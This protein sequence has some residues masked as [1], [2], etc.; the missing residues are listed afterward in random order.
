MIRKIETTAADA[1]LGLTPA[2]LVAFLGSLPL[3][4]DVDSGIEVRVVA[5]W[6]GQIKSISGRFAAPA[7]ARA[8]Q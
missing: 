8:P 4:D 3:D 1:K 6:H 5:G 7:P 2:E